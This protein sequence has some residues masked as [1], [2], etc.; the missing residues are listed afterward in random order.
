LIKVIA[1]D[2]NG[3]QI[4]DLSNTVFTLYRPAECIGGQVF[5]LSDTSN[6]TVTFIGSD[7]GYTNI[8]RLDSPRYTIL[9][10]GHSTPANTTWDI[11]RFLVG[12]ELIFADYV[13]DT[14]RTY[15]TGPPSRNPDSLYHAKVTQ[16]TEIRFRAGFEDMFGGGDL[17]FNDIEFYVIGDIILS[18]PSFI[19]VSSPIGGENWQRDS[20]HPITWIVSNFDVTSYT[21]QYS[22][23]SGYSWTDIITGLSGSSTSYN[24][25]IPWITT[26]HARVRV[27]GFNSTGA[28][29]SDQSKDD[30]TISR[31]GS[32]YS[33]DSSAAPVSSLSVASSETTASW[34]APECSNNFGALYGRTVVN[35]F[36][37]MNG[38]GVKD[39][40]EPNIPGWMITTEYES[41]AGGSTLFNSSVTDAQGY[42][43][44]PCIRNDRRYTITEAESTGW[45]NST[46]SSVTGMMVASDPTGYRYLSFGNRQ[47]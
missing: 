20:T 15:Y 23:N 4:S 10:N 33:A 19:M 47:G 34:M 9:G 28:Q 1:Y 25:H 40:G 41:P 13:Q 35:K 5:V 37:D 31:Y 38:N 43:C 39:A 18:C 45:R 7:A 27:I 8:F 32:S 3:N 36:N 22:T 17:D 11:G 21:L 14:S 2:A 44:T 46:P 42:Y 29:L 30:F 6:V 26:D 12:Q 24:W 16:E